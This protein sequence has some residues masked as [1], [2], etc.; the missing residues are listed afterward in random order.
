[1]KQP[2]ALGRSRAALVLLILLQLGCRGGLFTSSAKPPE[3]SEVPAAPKSVMGKTGIDYVQVPAGEFLMGSNDTNRFGE[4]AVGESPRHKV[5]ITR[6]FWMSRCEVTVAQFRKFVESTGYKTEPEESGEGSF[7]LDIKTGEIARAP[8]RIWSNPGYT[9]GDNHP[10]VCVSWKDAT[11][12]CEWLS[13][14][15][16]KTCRLPTEAEWEYAC[17]AGTDTLLATGEDLLSLQGAANMADG[18][19]Q[20][21]YASAGGCAPWNDGYAFTSTVGS[22][23]PNRFGLFDMHGNVAEWCQDWYDAG[24][25]ANSPAKDPQGPLSG[26]WRVVRGGSWYNTASCGRS[27][28]RHDNIATSPATTNG[29]RVVM[30]D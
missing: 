12:Y 17:R 3:I 6:A 24:Y 8:E 21:V 10:V 2:L 26:K 11:A 23:I 16:G 22:F 28:G 30:V 27:S 20:T 4:T 19:L 9:Q 29:F 13:K 5:E 1:M 7:A 25:Y 18:A 14:Q 15:E